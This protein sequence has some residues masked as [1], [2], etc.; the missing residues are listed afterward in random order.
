MTE[1]A[2]IL[3]CIVLAGLALFQLSLIIGLPYGNYAWGGAH[4]VLPTKLRIGSAVSIVLY[5]LFGL[6]ILG[7]AELVNVIS[8]SAFGMWI[9]T[10]YF[11]VGV[12]MNGISRS[13]KER[14]VMTP[15]SLV[16]ALLCL[17]V[18]LN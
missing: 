12:L 18:A 13:K 2:A 10:A 11:F 9:L 14:A 5:I 6:V 17:V 16:L 8:S 7:D 3:A 1:I 15:V 4:K